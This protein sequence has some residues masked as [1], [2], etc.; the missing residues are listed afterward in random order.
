MVGRRILASQTGRGQ[1]LA[2]KRPIAMF[3]SGEGG[4]TVLKQARALFPGEDYLYVCDSAHF[5]Y[6]D[7]SLSEVRDFFLAIL[8]FMLTQD[9]QA[10]VIACNTATAAALAEARRMAPVPVIGVVQA[11]VEAAARATQNRRVGVLETLATHRSQIYAKS[12]TACDPSIVVLERPCP[13]LVVL[14]ENGWTD[15]PECVDAVQ[16]CA[17][18]LIDEGVD[19]LILGCTHFPHM[20]KVFNQVVAGRAHVIDP[21][22]ETARSLPDYLPDLSPQG[23]QGNLAFFTTGDPEDSARVARLLWPEVE[24]KPSRLVWQGEK[25][26]MANPSPNASTR[27]P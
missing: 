21:G 12:L 13:L 10:V 5:P 17:G 18:G 25:V 19:T 1:V 27:A 11:G 23:D 26:L 22:L 2:M 4:L 20:Q 8:E 6:G 24:V 15:G 7:R 14:A 9:P 3:D 16:Q